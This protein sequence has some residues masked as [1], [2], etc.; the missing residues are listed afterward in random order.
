MNIEVRDIAKALYNGNIHTFSKGTLTEDEANTIITNAILDVCDCKEKFNLNKFMDNRYKV[1]Q[2]LEDVISEPIKQGIVPQ[3]QEWMDIVSVG[4]NETYSFSVLN[5]ELFKVGMVA[6]GTHDFHRQRLINGKLNLTSFALGI[7][8][9]EE[10]HNLRTGKINFSQM[11]DRVIASFDSEIMR[12][13]VTMIQKAHTG[14]DAKYHI[15]ATYD[16]AKLIELVERVEAKTNKTA[17]IYGT[18]TALANLLDSTVIADSDKEDKR[19]LGHVRIWNGIKV[20]LIPQVLDAEDEFVVDNKT[21]FV[22]P[23][24]TKIVKLLFEGDAEVREV[25]SEEVRDDQQFEFAFMQRIQLGV[26]KSSIYGLY[27]IQ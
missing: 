18:R 6:G 25:N 10:F 1:F 27:E 21:L 8:I 7:K 24:G 2:I 5:N 13:A 17:V 23:E 26:A 20:V 16:E 14:L 12:M 19:N 9:Y 22:L 4:Y 3:Y 11:I 15:K